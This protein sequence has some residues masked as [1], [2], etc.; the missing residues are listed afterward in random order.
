MIDLHHHLLFGIDDGCQ[1][2]RHPP[3]PWSRWPRQTA[4]RTLSR[5]PHANEEYPYDRERN[6]ALLQQIRDALSARDSG[7][8][9][10]R[11]R[12]RTFT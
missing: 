7:K 12:L 10:S 11:P 5:R 2:S 8:D 9:A 4:S 3:S 6:T 1:R